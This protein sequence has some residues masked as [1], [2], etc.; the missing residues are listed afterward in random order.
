[1]PPRAASLPTPPAPVV[2][3]D[4]RREGPATIVEIDERSH[5]SYSTYRLL[6][7]I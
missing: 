7:T 3:G 4:S 5:F 2:P 1:M 6:Q